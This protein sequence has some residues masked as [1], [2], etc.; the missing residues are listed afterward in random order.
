VTFDITNPHI[1]N[2]HIMNPHIMN[3]HIMNPHIMNPHIMNRGRRNFAR[4]VDDITLS[5]A[6]R[7]RAALLKCRRSWCN[8]CGTRDAVHCKKPTGTQTY[9]EDRALDLLL[10]SKRPATK[11]WGTGVGTELHAF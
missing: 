2:P 3:P 11:S 8:P 10:G 4:G 5:Q 6:P 7:N 1:M 9:S